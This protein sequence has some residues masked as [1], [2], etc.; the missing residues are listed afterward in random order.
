MEYSVAIEKGNKVEIQL[1]E[2]KLDESL[3]PGREKTIK[4]EM[5]AMQE[6][7][8]TLVQCW[9]ANHG[10]TEKRD[11]PKQPTSV[12]VN[13]QG[14]L[15]DADQLNALKNDP[16]KGLDKFLLERCEKNKLKFSDR[17]P[18]VSTLKPS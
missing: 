2:P 8:N 18:S 11:N 6:N 10:Y 9:L 1:V 15:L 12:Y 5:A 13:A 4:T 7:F 16:D 14:A 17:S 3:D